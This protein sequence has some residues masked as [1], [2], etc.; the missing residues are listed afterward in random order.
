[1]SLSRVNG[2]FDLKITLI[3]KIE[4]KPEPQSLKNMDSFLIKMTAKRI[5][6]VAVMSQ[7]VF[8]TIR[9]PFK[10]P[11]KALQIPFKCPLNAL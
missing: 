11:S 2:T 7:T 10:C 8:K 1:M 9:L 6:A 3:K 4:Q 5:V